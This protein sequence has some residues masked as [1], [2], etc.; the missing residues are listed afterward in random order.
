MSSIPS[1]RYRGDKEPADGVYQP[2]W[3]D[4]EAADWVQRYR[5]VLESGNISLSG[6]SRTTSSLDGIPQVSNND[7]RVYISRETDFTIIRKSFE[8]VKKI[9]SVS[10]ISSFMKT[11]ASRISC[12]IGSGFEHFTIKNCKGSEKELSLYKNGSFMFNKN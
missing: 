9:F 4:R 12:R 10:G 2:Q 5:L 3:R 8:R 7:A 11:R 6:I 1:R